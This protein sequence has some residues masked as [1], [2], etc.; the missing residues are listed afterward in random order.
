MVELVEH[1][2]GGAAI[3]KHQPPEVGGGP[4]QRVGGHNE[5]GGPVEAVCERG[6][7]VV[8]ALALRGHQEGQGAVGWQ[9]VHAAV[10]LPV[11][12]QQGDAAL[13]HVDVGGDRVQS[14]QGERE[15]ET[16]VWRHRAIGDPVAY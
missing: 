11:P 5:R 6:V 4:G 3:V 9:H 8:V 13:L 7:D 10:L 15:R 2:N 1:D 14:L 12:R 16:L